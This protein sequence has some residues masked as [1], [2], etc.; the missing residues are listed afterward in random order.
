M[1][2]ICRYLV[3]QIDRLVGWRWTVLQVDG[4]VLQEIFVL[5]KKLEII[6]DLWIFWNKFFSERNKD[7][8]TSLQG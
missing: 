7:D 8:A 2:G 1:D 3:F 6:C 4:F 5:Q